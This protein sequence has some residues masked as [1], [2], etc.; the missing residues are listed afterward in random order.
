MYPVSDAFHTAVQNGNPQMALMIFPD[1]V[2]TNA[3]IDVET[4]IT[5]N[6]YF[7]LEKSLKIGQ[8]P[9]NQISFTLFND[10]KLL[11]NYAFGDFLAT[12]GVRVGTDNYSGSGNAYVITKYATYVGSSTRPYLTRNGQAVTSQPGWPVVSILSY[13]DKV[14]VFGKNKSQYAVYNDTNGAAITASNTVNAFMRDKANKYWQGYGIF[15]NKDSRILFIYKNETGERERYEF[16]PFGHF[17]AERPDS[18]N[19]ISIDLTCYDLMQR[20]DIDMPTA[21]QMGISYPTTIG[22]LFKKLC[23]YVGLPYRTTTFIN[24]TATISEEPEDFENSTARTVLG[25]IAEAAAS[26]ARIDRDGYVILDWIRST[27]QSYSEGDYTSCEPYW[28][29]TKKVTKLYNRDTSEADETTYGSG[30]E[31]YLIQDNP[32]LT[33]AT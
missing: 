17:T 12:A 26:N 20:F 24:S 28:Y 11:N 31:P 4:G 30:D 32:L 1:A 15:Y 7:N 8:T 13:N 22:N 19:K 5:F 14:Y 9:S 27:N 18:P 33:D 25:W 10:D 23:E 3:D 2:F 16:C 29:E 6:D 21:S